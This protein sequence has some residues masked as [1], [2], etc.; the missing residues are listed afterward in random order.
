MT[1]TEGIGGEVEWSEG[2]SG[3][4]IDRPNLSQPIAQLHTPEFE[5]AFTSK[6]DSAELDNK[7]ILQ[8]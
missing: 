3:N 2:L 1:S 7:S 4:V 8:T 5:S 6:P